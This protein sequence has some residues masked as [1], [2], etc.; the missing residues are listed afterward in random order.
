[1]LKAR[2]EAPRPRRARR[3]P[4]PAVR[5]PRL[6]PGRRRGSTTPRCCPPFRRVIFDEAH[7]VEKAA[8]SFFS[9]SFYRFSLM[10]YLN[11]LHR[12]RKGRVT[13]LV[14]T[15][16]EDLGQQ[17]ASKGVPGLIARV[18]ETAEALDARCARPDGRG[19]DDPP[20]AGPCPRLA[21]AAGRLL[22]DLSSSI[23]ELVEA[24]AEAV[25]KAGG[26]GA[27]R[28]G[29][30][31]RCGSAGC[32]SPGCRDR[33]R[34]RPV[35]RGRDRRERHLLDGGAARRRGRESRSAAGAPGDHAPRRSGRSC[36]RPCTSRCRTVVFTSATLTVAG[37][38]S[39]WAGRIGL[40][41]RAARGRR[42]GSRCSARFP[43]P[44]DYREN[45]LLGVP[46]D[47]PAPDAPGH[48]EFLVAVPQRRRL[49]ASRGAGLVLFTSYALLR[50]MHEAVRAGARRARASVSCARER[51]TGRACSSR[52]AHE[53]LERALRHRLVLG[54]G[55]RA[56]GDAAGGG[57]VPAA[58]PRALGARAEGR[59]AAIEADG[60]NPFVELSLPDAVVRMRQGFGRLMRRHDDQGRGAGPRFTDRDQAVRRGVPRIAAA[61]PRAIGPAAEVLAAVNGFFG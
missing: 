13:G 46:T 26:E 16:R 29:G 9:Q 61:H 41:R 40:G 45:V 52:S 57:A 54:R 8:T 34:L 36:A 33:G 11:R 30:E 15:P 28:R 32:S 48:R 38:F 17:R 3:Q 1:M 49:L 10:R 51:R 6:P 23:R 12:R 59:M 43:S 18:R 37:S 44:F 4:P 21:E 31:R 20:R 47:A 58:L 39:Y 25:E 7:N 19:G 5:R 60:G 24:F 27:S 53:T 22:A 50:E 55:G 14:P 35:P 56:G 2:R 42:T